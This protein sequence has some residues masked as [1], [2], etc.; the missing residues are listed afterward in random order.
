[1]H[2]DLVLRL[3]EKQIVA[4]FQDESSFQTNEYKQ[5]IWC[6]P[7]NFLF[8]EPLPLGK[9][10]L[11][12]RTPAMSAFHFCSPSMG[13][14]DDSTSMDSFG[15]LQIDNVINKLC[16]E[17]SIHDYQ[18]VKSILDSI[19]PPL[20]MASICCL[21]LL[22]SPMP[23]SQI[24]ASPHIVWASTRGP[25]FT[26]PS[27]S[28]ATPLDFPPPFAMMMSLGMSSQSPLPLGQCRSPYSYSP[29]SL[30]PS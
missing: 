18:V 24:P 22:S 8:L 29:P 26:I 19:Y 4:L 17:F 21:S 13:N 9:G 15:N 25:K 12:N 16:L 11:P 5:M 14:D 3:G 2:I 10:L 1:M 28:F 20:L 7:K 6:I 23:R 30:G 27:L